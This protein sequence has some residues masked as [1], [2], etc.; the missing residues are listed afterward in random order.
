MGMTKHM[1]EIVL[2]EHAYKPIEG[3]ILLCGRQSIFMTAEEAVALVGS[4][5]LLR[6]VEPRI[7]SQTRGSN[8][9]GWIADDS[10]FE[11]FADARFNAVDVSGYEG[12][13][14]VHDMCTP[15]ADELA[16]KFNFIF[17]GSCMDN[18]SNPAAFLANTSRMLAPGG[19]IIHIEHGSRSR[20][21]YLMYSPDYFFDFYARNG[22]AD[23]K[24]YMALFE[25]SHRRSVWRMFQWY[26]HGEHEL[27][28]IGTGS[29]AMIVTVAEKAAGSTDDV[30]PI[31]AH[32]RSEADRPLYLEAAKRY[33]ASKRPVYQGGV[34]KIPEES[35]NFPA[36]CGL[37][38]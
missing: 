21:A 3:E 9:K 36:Y 38:S 10:F 32:Y 11:L 33:Q 29:G 24:V 35:H 4:H 26:P 25:N 28:N 30:F 37:L 34:P 17:N 2:R 15:I 1:A 20:G 19:V 5:N 6:G 7:D 8:D 16:G 13:N 23:C 31:Q 18:L 12:A 22:Y 14:I 27:S